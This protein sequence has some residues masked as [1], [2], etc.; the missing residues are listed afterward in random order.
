[1]NL[2]IFLLFCCA[3]IGL[4]NIIV[5]PAVIFKP[6]RDFIAKKAETNKIIA[7]FNELLS[8]YQCTGF[9]V[10]LLCGAILSSNIFLIMLAAPAGRF[11]AT[12][13]ALFLN[14]LESKSV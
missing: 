14:Y 13:G 7:F 5:D 6:I 10:G 9:W 3:V 4:T 12:M 2:G 1:M 8:C 11:I